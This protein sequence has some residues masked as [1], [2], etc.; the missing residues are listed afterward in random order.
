MKN[1]FSRRDFLKLS[2]TL[3]AGLVGLPY[4]KLLPSSQADASGKKNVLIIVFDAF[5]ARHISAYGYQRETTPN[6]A[7]LAERAIVYHNHHAGGNY[8]TPGTASLLTGTL[9]WKHRAFSYF[10]RVTDTLANKSIFHAFHDYHRVAYTHN[11]L[12]VELLNQFSS[13]LEEN[14]PIEQFLLNYDG[15]I[16]DLFPKDVDVAS[17]SWSRLTKGEDEY[18]SYSLF[19]AAMYQTYLDKKFESWNAQF[20]R[21]LP[22][23]SGKN[24]F[25]LEM[26]LDWLVSQA[27][28]FPRPFLG[29]FHFI[30]P[31]QPYATRM[32]FYNVF[33]NDGYFPPVKKE[34]LFS[35]GDPLNRMVVRRQ[36]YDEYILYVDR[37]FGKLMDRLDESGVLDDTWVVLTSDHGEMFERGIIGHVTHLLYEPVVHIPLMIFEPGRS[38]RTDVFAP[39][40]AVDLLPT[41]LSVTGGSMPDWTEGSILPPFSSRD[42]GHGAYTVQ[43]RDTL[44]NEPL[45]IASVMLVKDNHKLM[46]LKG[47]EELQGE[48][49]IELYDLAEDPEE[50]NNIYSAGSS[51]G[52]AML[53]ELK[54]KLSEMNKPYL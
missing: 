28:Q 13:G 12:A 52:R 16:T 26:V 40:S 43:A 7:R 23:V 32:E 48:E 21:G 20:P 36:Q 5:S 25:T 31:H 4:L 29:Y 53:D 47:Y 6:I 2:A 45:N 39:T 38:T 15:F 50:L 42:V 33:N 44:A 54:T 49:R 3:S 8:T 9:P 19:L 37:E 11:P 27:G 34:D 35:R 24:Y 17:M 10:D 1:N 41:L 51:I 18:S 14:I 22:S 46:Y 30:P